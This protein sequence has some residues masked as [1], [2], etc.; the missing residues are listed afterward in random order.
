VLHRIVGSFHIVARKGRGWVS[1]KCVGDYIFGSRLVYE[2]NDVMR[3]DAF[4]PSGL[5]SGNV[6]LI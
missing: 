1:T 6:G 5:D 2:M 3:V 4:F